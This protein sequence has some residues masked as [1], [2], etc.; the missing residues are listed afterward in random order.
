M[1]FPLKS[2]VRWNAR[3]HKLGRV[4]QILEQIPEENLELMVQLFCTP[5]EDLESLL[6]L[7]NHLKYD[8]DTRTL[9]VSGDIEVLIKGEGK[10][11]STQEMWID[12]GWRKTNPLTQQPYCIRLNDEDKKS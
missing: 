4:V 12:S 2:S 8:P 3:A 9:E 6:A 5:K 10:L 11:S 1:E 7:S